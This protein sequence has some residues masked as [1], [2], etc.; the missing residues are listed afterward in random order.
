MDELPRPPELCAVLSNNAG[1]YAFTESAGWAYTAATQWMLGVMPSFAGLVVDPCIHAEWKG[2]EISRQWRGA[3]DMIS[4]KNPNGI[5]RGV[6]SVT[7]N[8]MPVTGAIPLQPTGSTN[9]VVVVMG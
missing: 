6:R 5:Q 7:L 1:G 3:M 2:S 4:V 8:G 9:D